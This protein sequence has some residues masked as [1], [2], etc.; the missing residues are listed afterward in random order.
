[1]TFRRPANKKIR[2]ELRA[3]APPNIMDK[4]GQLITDLIG[5]GSDGIV[6]L[7]IYGF[8]PPIGN[9]AIAARLLAIRV[10]NLVPYSKESFGK[11]LTNTMSGLAEQK[12]M[13]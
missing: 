9:P 12:P 8:K 2:G 7:E 13:F 10:D 11:D 6:K 1:M 4:S 3:F 5:N